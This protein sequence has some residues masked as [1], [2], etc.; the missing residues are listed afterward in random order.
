[1]RDNGPGFFGCIDLG[2]NDTACNSL[3]LECQYWYVTY[4]APASNALLIKS[5]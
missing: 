4:C 2:Y 5:A 1:M 3:V